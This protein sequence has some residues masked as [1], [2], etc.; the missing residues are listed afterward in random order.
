MTQSPLVCWWAWSWGSYQLR[1]LRGQVVPSRPGGQDSAPAQG[2]LRE[3]CLSAAVLSHTVRLS[4]FWAVSPD[5]VPLLPHHPPPAR[6][7]H[8]AP[9]TGPG[10]A[11]VPVGNSAGP[12]SA[13]TH[14][15][16]LTRPRSISMRLDTLLSTELVLQVGI[17]LEG[18]RCRVGTV[19]ISSIF[20]KNTWVRITMGV[21]K[22]DSNAGRGVGGYNACF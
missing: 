7:P 3:S 1:C 4:A 20:W 19:G 15:M 22:A 6:P 11:Q 14:C 9:G 13:F 18:T 2:C 21:L 16:L 12:S 10:T 5:A 17:F 8:P